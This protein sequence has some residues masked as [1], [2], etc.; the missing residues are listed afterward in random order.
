MFAEAL[1]V[2]IFTLPAGIAFVIIGLLLWKKQ[3]IQLIHDYHH[4]NVKQQDVKAYTRLWGIALIIFGG[5][6][7]SI[8]IIDFIFRSPIGWIPSVISMVVCF[9]IGNKAQKTY[10]GSW[11]S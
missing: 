5:G 7:C 3:K 6:I 1:I 8:G 2:T 10:N 11:F 9:I 4:K